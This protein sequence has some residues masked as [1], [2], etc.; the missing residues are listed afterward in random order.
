MRPSTTARIAAAALG[1]AM[2]DLAAALSAATND[3]AAAVG[4]GTGARCMPARP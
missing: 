2:A 3:V 1:A 4:A